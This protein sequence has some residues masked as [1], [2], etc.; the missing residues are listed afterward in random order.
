[1]SDVWTARNSRPSPEGRWD[2]PSPAEGVVPPAPGEFAL[3]TSRAGA[4]GVPGHYQ[5]RLH[6][7]VV[8]DDA[9]AADSLALL[10]QADG[11]GVQVAR[12]GP[13]ALRF[14]EARP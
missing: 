1:M 8:E 5:R 12:D 11:H 14:A 4:A 3:P 6:I 7:L 13:S 2:G 9:D 10:L